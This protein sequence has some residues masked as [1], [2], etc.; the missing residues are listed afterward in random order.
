MLLKELETQVSQ[1]RGQISGLQ[2][3]VR[4]A[5]AGRTNVRGMVVASGFQ[6]S[7]SWQ[8]RNSGG[9][10]EIRDPRSG[11]V[12]ARFNEEQSFQ[13]LDRS[14]LLVSDRV[15]IGTTSPLA[16]LDVRGEIRG[17]MWYRRYTWRR[18]MPP[19]RMGHSSKGLAALTWVQ[20]SFAGGGERVSVDVGK[21]GYWYLHG[22]SGKGSIIAH[23]VFWGMP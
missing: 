14:D 7:D 23:G 17:K 1:L 13:L 6:A 15:G 3:T 18:G 19:V 16:K 12:W 22:T 5:G 4:P 20:G 8:L 10:L 11:K 9:K 2:Q 21:D